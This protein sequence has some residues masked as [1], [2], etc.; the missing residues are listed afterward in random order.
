MFE[1]QKRGLVLGGEAEAG[2]LDRGLRMENLVGC[3]KEDTEESL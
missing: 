3:Q 1:R 2:E